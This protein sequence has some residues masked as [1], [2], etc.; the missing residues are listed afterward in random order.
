MASIGMQRPLADY[1]KEEVLILVEVVI[2]AY[3]E[4]MVN[5]KEIPF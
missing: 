3:Q 1:S 5:S 2:T 4:F